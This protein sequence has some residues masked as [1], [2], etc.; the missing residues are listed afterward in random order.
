M[1][2][3][4][5][6]TGKIRK[7]QIGI[8]VIMFANFP[9]SYISLK[10]GLGPNSIYVVSVV[11]CFVAMIYRIL[12]IKRLLPQIN[13][14]SFCFG[15]LYQPLGLLVCTTLMYYVL[16]ELCVT[17]SFMQVLISIIMEMAL[18]VLILFWGMN[19]S[20]RNFIQNILIS[21]IRKWIR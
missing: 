3:I 7:Y 6:A 15:L 17:S 9:F 13:F 2:K 4:I 10:L 20:E 1:L 14:K 8:S 5:I 16:R 12:T 11:T 18:V 21:K 19:L